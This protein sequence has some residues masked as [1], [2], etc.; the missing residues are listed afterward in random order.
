NRAR[1]LLPVR[2]GRD[3]DGVGGGDVDRLTGLRVAPGARGALRALDGQEA[4]D[5]N[6]LAAGDRLDELL[7]ETGDDR[8]DGRGRDVGA[9]RDGGDQFGLVHE[10]P[11]VCAVA[12]PGLGT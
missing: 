7:L 11:L 9:L 10:V 4:G 12:V 6:L 2:A 1:G 5:G 3:L 8:V